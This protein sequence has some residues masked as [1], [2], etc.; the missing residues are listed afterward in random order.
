MARFSLS[1]RRVDDRRRTEIV[2]S[3]IAGN[4]GPQG[5]ADIT[6]ESETPITGSKSIIIESL[7]PL[8]PDTIRSDPLLGPLQ[9]NGG[10]TPTHAVLAGSPAID[11]GLNPLGLSLDQRAFDEDVPGG[12]ERQVGNGTDIGAFALGAPDRIFTEG[13]EA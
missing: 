3:I 7:V 6:S 13:F 12:Y 1:R 4:T 2:S 11:Q 5:P 9:D 10:L 8:P